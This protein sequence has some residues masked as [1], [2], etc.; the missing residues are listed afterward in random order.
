[1]SL[2]D[3]IQEIRSLLDAYYVHASAF[4]VAGDDDRG[5]PLDMQVGEVDDE[6]WVQWRITEPR[7]TLNDIASLEKRFGIEFPNYF[8][9]YLLAACHLFD[10]IHSSKY[11]QLI[12]MTHVPSN[13]P[14]GPLESLLSSWQPLISASF[15]PFAEWGD[16]WGPMCFDAQQ[17][18]VDDCPIVWMDHELLIP[19]GP[20]A[21]GD[22]EAV[23]PHVQSLYSNTIEFIDD[24][25]KVA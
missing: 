17:R 5:V 13:K 15:I 1:M 9:A 22:R 10:Q 6:G 24:V 20:E 8:R 19:L 11:E 16:G 7:V 18:S 12:F 23:M 2:E 21:C 4:H 3:D 14:L 25:F